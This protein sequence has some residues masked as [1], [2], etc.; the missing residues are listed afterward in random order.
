MVRLTHLSIALIALI[1]T[2]SAAPCY[3]GA[4]VASHPDCQTD[5][6][7][8]VNN[9]VHD[10]SLND[11]S[12]NNK[13]HNGKS[14]DDGKDY[15]SSNDSDDSCDDDDSGSDGSGKDSDESGDGGLVS[16]FNHGSVVNGDVKAKNIV[17]DLIHAHVL[18]K[19]DNLIDAFDH[20]SVVNGDVKAKN[21]V[22]D[23][24]HAHVG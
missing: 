17:N 14:L 23:P 8:F 16:L 2:T 9:Q 20:G 11:K 7:P 21:I 22:N 3:G 24:I 13:P 6:T 18:G 15:M 4:S 5:Y 10:K 1:V 12:H 19:R